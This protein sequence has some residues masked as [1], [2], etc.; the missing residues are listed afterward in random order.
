MKEQ[1]SFLKGI[2][3]GV[4]ICLG[5]LSISFAFGIFACGSGFSII[6]AVLMSM[7]NLTS[8]GQL[9]AVP[10][11][12]AG[13]TFAELAISQIVINLRYA[14][15]SVSLSQ[16]LGKSVKF[17]DRFLMSF[18]MTDEIFAVSYSNDGTVG[19][20]YFYGLMLTPYIGWSGGT[21]LGA[22]AGNILPSSV[23]SA[24]GIAIYG[25]FIAIVMPK[26]KTER[27]TALCVGLAVLLSCVFYFVPALKRVP[28]GFV[29]IICAAVASALF[30]FIAPLNISE[31]DESNA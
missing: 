1:N 15:M 3:D 27:K 24:L 26:V 22:C 4:P 8:A 10:I 20:R 7:T 29:I 9:A 17:I 5:Y 16:K 12:A 21:L 6:E 28:S 14:L 31:E 13:G 25:M 11:I 18:S 19:K 2:K 30:A 23:V